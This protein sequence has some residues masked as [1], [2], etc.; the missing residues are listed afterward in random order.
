VKPLDRTRMTLFWVALFCAAMGVYAWRHFGAAR[1]GGRSSGSADPGG[2]AGAAS[3][4]AAQAG[5]PTAQAGVFEGFCEASALV[6]WEGGFLVGDNET[7]D[8]LFSFS[9]A[10]EP[11]P[12]LVLGAVVKDIEA[13]AVTPSGLLVVGSQSADKKGHLEKRRG[14]ALLVGPGGAADAALPIHPDFEQCP[15][16]EAARGR[17]PK[18]GGLSVE[19]AAMGWGA[20][21]FGLR[22]PLS[23]GHA[24]ILRMAG[25]PS[26]G[27]RVEETVELSIG[28]LG[29]R[30]LLPWDGGLLVLAGPSGRGPGSH[31]LF[32]LRSRDEA[33]EDLGV[34][35]PRSSEGVAVVASDTVLV[36]TDGDGKPGSTC[37]EPA[38]WE[39]VVVP[40]L[41]PKRAGN[42]ADRPED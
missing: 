21:W 34:E 5:T 31:R 6:A 23:G 14:L 13:L 24:L 25:D 15:V 9:S 27:L 42:D 17:A 39:Q 30:D 12:P 22:S 35:L 29:I 16:C 10:L 7:E 8:R 32:R 4:A 26:R 28:G 1:P 11:K 19:G 18:E 20:L 2:A 41:D 38:T 40:G 36:V 3:A 33:P 37:A